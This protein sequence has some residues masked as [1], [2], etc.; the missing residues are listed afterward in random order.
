[1]IYLNQAATT[2]P[3][4]QRVQEALA[5]ALRLPPPGQYRGGGGGAPDELFSQ[6]RKNM[7]RILGLYGE[8]SAETA[9][10]ERI[11]FTSGATDAANR[12]LYGLFPEKKVCRI[13]TTATEHNSVLRPLYNLPRFAEGLRIVPCGSSGELVM[14]ALADAVTEG[15]DAVILNHCSNV[16]GA[17]QNLG[18]AARIAHE[19]GALLLADCSQSAGC[20]EID[21]ARADV[22]ALIFT[23]HKGLFGVQG[24]GGYYL[25]RGIPLRPLLY[26]GTGRNS[27]QLV[28]DGDYEYEVGTQ[29]GIG[30]AALRAGTEFV[31]EEEPARIAAREREEMEYLSRELQEI[32]GIAVYG[33]RALC[34][35]PVLSFNL[36][37][38]EAADTAYVLQNGYGIAVRA[39]LHCAPLIHERIGSGPGG[40]VRVSISALTERAELDALLAA[41]REIAEARR[42]AR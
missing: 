3:K 34:R 24:T 15:T 36:T 23:G 37:D 5:A 7:A 14:E 25:K 20:M 17:V 26:G 9:P 1:M 39:G 41:L 16:T 33:S 8:P 12:L 10:E 18:E 31:L 38:M 29:N 32:P 22:D 2:Y 19:R 13:V 40:T 28:Y 4:P 42:A 35:G 27:R 6:C 21:A 11:F 30:I